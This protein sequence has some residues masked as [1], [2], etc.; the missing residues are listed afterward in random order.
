[1]APG[2]CGSKAHAEHTLGCGGRRVLVS[3]K[4]TG[5]TLKIHQAD[6]AEVVR[7]TLLA[8][9]VEV[10]ELERIDASVVREDGQ[11]RFQW[12]VWDPLE[13]RAPVY[14]QVMTRAIAQRIQWRTDY[15]AAKARA[16][17]T[18]APPRPP[19][20]QRPLLGVASVK[21]ERSELT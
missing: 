14:R 12:R 4:W 5:K 3:R 7:Q 17:P 2:A 19:D 10:P 11:Q 13:A 20:N 16:G 6:R 9:G 15:E 8:A 1:M 18:N 21:G